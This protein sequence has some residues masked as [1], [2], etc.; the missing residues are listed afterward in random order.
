M[1]NFYEHDWSKNNQIIVKGFEKYLREHDIK[2]WSYYA[3]DYGERT[4]IKYL[5][6]RFL[7]DVTPLE[8]V[9]VFKMG[10]EFPLKLEGM[11]DY[12]KEL[13][14]EMEEHQIYFD[15]ICED[16]ILSKLL[17]DFPVPKELQYIIDGE[18]LSPDDLTVSTTH[19]FC[20]LGAGHRD[21]SKRLQSALGEQFKLLVIYL[22]R[23]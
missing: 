8:A 6:Y 4:L 10:Q 13:Y 14:G 19:A 12:W 16:K 9:H 17:R 1:A 7:T 21:I 22:K 18:Y 20:W 2:R 23:K 11:K 15:D 5:E 3:G